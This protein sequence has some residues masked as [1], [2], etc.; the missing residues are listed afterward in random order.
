M[1]ISIFKIL[2]DMAAEQA[3]TKGHSCKTPQNISGLHNQKPNKTSP[4]PGPSVA[5]IE[6]D[7]RT[8]H[9][10]ASGSPSHLGGEDTDPDMHDL[11]NGEVG[12]ELIDQDESRSS[13]TSPGVLMNSIFSRWW[14]KMALKTQII[15]Q[16]REEG[17]IQVTTFSR[18][19]WWKMTPKMQIIL[20]NGEEGKFFLEVILLSPSECSSQIV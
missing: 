12:P 17:K 20:Q 5:G 6:L 4:L 10:T 8:P 3:L 18:W 15:P 13:K 14:W 19:W 16:N 9:S 7:G 11:A 2:A 1:V